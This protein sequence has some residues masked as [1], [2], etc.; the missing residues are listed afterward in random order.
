[1]NGAK[2]LHIWLVRHARAGGNRLHIL[3]GSRR[4]VPLTAKGRKDGAR[5][6]RE[7]KFK[8]DVLLTSP[9]KRTFQTAKYFEEKFGMKARKFDLI[10]EH[11]LG[12]WTGKSAAKLKHKYPDYFFDYENGRKSHFLKKVPGGESWEDTKKRAGKAMREIKRKY[13][14]KKVVAI[15]HGIFSVACINLIAK[16]KPPKLWNYR[17]KNCEWVEFVL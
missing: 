7:W 17:L 11:D 13:K 1:M 2:K 8:P 9:M 6:A 3:N 5:L 14:G 15:S 12:D 10:K 16:I 4:D